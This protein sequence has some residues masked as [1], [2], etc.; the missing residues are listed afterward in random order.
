MASTLGRPG[1]QPA[2]QGDATQPPPRRSAALGITAGVSAAL[3][4]LLVVLGSTVRVTESGMGCPGWPLCYGQ[5]GPVDHFHAL[6][7]QSHRYLVALVVV[8]VVATALLAHRDGP[9]RSGLRRGAHSALAVVAVQVVL[10]AVTVWAHNAPVTVALHLAVGL[11]FLGVVTATAVLA[12]ER[13]TP[14]LRS[15]QGAWPLAP[16]A[17]VGTFL[18]MVSGSVVVDGGA[19]ASCRAW[20]GCPRSGTSGPLIDLQLAHRAVVLAASV[21]IV[22]L[23]GVAWRQWADTRGTR[24]LASALV[25]MLAA[26]VAMGAVVALLGAPPWAQDVHL[27]LASA[28]W[29]S[30]VGLAT[31]GRANWAPRAGTPTR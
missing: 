20:P 1:R 6:L 5:L 8:F 14:V 29:C 28:I 19:A 2:E 10:G 9:R 26:Q 3:T 17:L 24:P 11:L 23:A 18:L 25:V 4:F 31:L 30:V 21:L 7:E 27:A 16:S 22:A 12:S 15:R 13:D